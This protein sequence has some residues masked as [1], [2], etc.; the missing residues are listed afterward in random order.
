LEHPVSARYITRWLSAGAAAGTIAALGAC[1]GGSASSATVAEAKKNIQFVNTTAAATGP[2]AQAVWLLPKE[3]GSLDLSNDNAN[4]QSDV[5]MTNVCEKLNRLNP[6]MTVGPGLA[7]KY[8]WTTPTTLTFT[9]RD[10]VTFHDGAR[11]TVDDVLWSMKRNA[12]E[13]NSEADEFVNVKSF[14]QSGP[15]Q[16]TF[17]MT[18]PDAVFVEALAGDAGLVQ[19]RKSVEA[20]GKDFGGPTGKDACS[21]P[22]TLSEWRPGQQVVLKKAA[23]YWDTGRAAK[24]GELT[25]K[26]GSDDAIVNSLVTG[27]AQGAYLEN[28][29][30]GA[31]LSKTGTT[32]VSQGPDTRV[33]SLM[34]TERGGLADPNVRKAL[35][36]A[37]DRDGI[38]RAGFTGLGQPYKEPVGSGAWGYERETFQAAYDKLAGSPAKP[39]DADIAEAEKMVSAAATTQPIVVASDG[40]SIRNVL[41]NAVVD[42]AQKIGLKAS[43]LQIPTAQYGDF[44]DNVDLRKKADLFADDYFISKNDPVG[45]YKNGASTSSVQ[46]VLKDP[47]Y[48]KLVKQGRAALD[49]KQRAAIA[50]EMAQKWADAKPWISAIQ[51]PSTVALSDKVTGVPASGSFHYYPWAADLG[52]KG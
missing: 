8:E 32:T 13:G 34:A 52:T 37:L 26:W 49:P 42:A 43:I 47:A 46:W 28:I 10:N 1:G 27:S 5:V 21:G 18:Q 6:D 3:P 17:T 12:T 41:A 2:L 40:S 22:F 31:R 48:D 39:S 14:A 24:T 4:D 19:E 9:L 16:I 23:Q 20:Q 44:Y 51:S 7:T 33:W 45:F 35:S 29:A 50:I 38:N 15:N 25:F 11:M 30:L 36:L